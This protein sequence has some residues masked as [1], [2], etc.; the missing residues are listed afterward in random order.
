MVADVVLDVGARLGEG[1]VWDEQAGE[2]LFVDI[3]SG[4]IHGFSPGSGEHRSFEAGMAVG[5]V[6]LDVA[7]GLVFAGADGFYSGVGFGGVLSRI[8]VFGVDATIVRFND[9]KVDPFGRFVAGT[10]SWSGRGPHGA[11]YLLDTDGSVR[12][13]LRQVTVSNG[14]AWG[15]DG[16]LMYYI[17]TPTH[18]VEVFDVDP[19][20]GALARRRR[21]AE[22]DGHPDG[23]ALDD[24]GMIWVAVA[25]GCRVE[26]IDPSSGRR[27][28]VVD[29]PVSQVTSVAFGGARLNELYITTGQG[30]LAAGRQPAPHAG[31]LF[32]VSPG[33]TGPPAYRYG[34]KPGFRST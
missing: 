15:D 13:L 17:D 32:A 4:T 34:P 18:L 8:G 21:I 20:T 30:M 24:E 23:M 1:P 16:R 10:M 9:G 29:V 14:L 6:V 3:L 5:A 19:T 11:L 27:L 2:L 31:D 22:V 28:A 12:E 26:R 33:V 7:G 25:G